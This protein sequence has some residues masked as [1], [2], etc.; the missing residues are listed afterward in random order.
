[1]ID[2]ELQQIYDKLINIQSVFEFS[3]ADLGKCSMDD[4]PSIYFNDLSISIYHVQIYSSPRGYYKS[5]QEPNYFQYIVEFE[6]GPD[7]YYILNNTN[8]SLA[9][10]HIDWEIKIL[11]D[12]K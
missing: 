9:I 8:K 6:Y 1:M 5:A 4:P 7:R 12:Y 3:Q 10:R 2:E 11:E